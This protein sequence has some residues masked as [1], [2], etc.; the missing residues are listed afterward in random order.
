MRARALVAVIAALAAGPA[1][2]TA[3]ARAQSGAAAQATAQA[4]ALAGD[5]GEAGIVAA[6]GDEGRADHA[7]AR[8]RGATIEQATTTARAASSAATPEAVAA[9]SAVGVSLAGGLVTASAVERTA[10]ARAGRVR[11]TGAV[12]GLVLDGTRVGDVRA[13]RT[14]RLTGATVVAGA[15]GDG[16]RLTLTRAVAGL[17]EGTTIVVARVAASAPAAAATPTPT[18][19]ATATPTATPAPT[20]TPGPSA[21]ERARARER[22]TV[23]RLARGDFTFPVYGAAS[24]ADTFGAAREIGAHQGDDVFAAFGTPVLA[25]ADGTVE[26]VGTLPISGNRLW[27]RTDRGDA[28]FYAHLSAFAPDAVD[29]R[30]VRKG[31]L[32]GFAGTTGDAEPTPPHLHFEIHPDDG[33]AIDPYRILVAWQTRDVP[34]ARGW[35]GRYGEDTAPRPGALVEVRDYITGG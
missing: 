17:P 27:L 2:T 13:T 26:R 10:T 18:P 7:S 1:G 8:R 12:R 20:A 32:L 6:E 21:T 11:Y 23:R 28:F 3:L 22:A 19:T 9:A 25:V 24:V 34:S 5:L 16:L 33:P 15:G 14:W 4:W 31:T 35:L 30:V 29:G